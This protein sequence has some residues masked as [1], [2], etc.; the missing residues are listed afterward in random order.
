MRNTLKSLPK[1]SRAIAFV[2]NLEVITE[3]ITD[4]FRRRQKGQAETFTLPI[5]LNLLES[6]GCMGQSVYLTCNMQENQENKFTTALVG[7]QSFTLVAKPDIIIWRHN[8]TVEGIDKV[9]ATASIAVRF[10]ACIYFIISIWNTYSFFSSRL[11]VAR[12][13]LHL[14]SLK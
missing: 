2:K 10:I 14:V 8:P 12:M 13:I 4:H 1:G 11:L 5:A 6:V 9:N 7:G 3:N